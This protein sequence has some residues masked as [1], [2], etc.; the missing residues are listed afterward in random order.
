MG[1]SLQM[2][3]STYTHVIEELRGGERQSAEELIKQAREEMLTQCSHT[4]PGVAIMAATV[5][6]KQSV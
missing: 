2:L 6:G 5:E 4:G 1:H 3:L